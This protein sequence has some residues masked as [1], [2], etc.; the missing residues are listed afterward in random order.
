MAHSAGRSWAGEPE[1]SD[2]LKSFGAIVKVFRERAGITQDALAA[3]VQYSHPMI[4]SIEQGRRLPPPDFVEKAEEALDAFLRQPAVELEVAVF[5]VAQHRVA[6]VREVHPDLVRPA[7]VE[8]HLEEGMVVPSRSHA[9]VG[10]SGPAGSNHGTA[11]RAPRVSVERG[12]DRPRR[13]IGHASDHRQVDATYLASRQG[14]SQGRMHL[15]VACHQQHPCSTAHVGEYARPIVACRARRQRRQEADRG[16][17][18]H[19]IL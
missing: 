12:I 18:R 6:R 8:R 15:V 2:S 5:G 1:T 19:G 3:L 14:T 11:G 10:A 9:V 4:S 16:A 13:Q 7:G 17:A